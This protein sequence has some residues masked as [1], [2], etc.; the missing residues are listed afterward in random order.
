M[1]NLELYRKFEKELLHHR[2][3][4]GVGNPNEFSIIDNMEKAWYSVSSE[5]Q[6]ILDAE[7]PQCF[8]S[9][10]YKEYVDTVKEL[11]VFQNE[12][13]VKSEDEHKLLDKMNKAWHNMTD[14][15]KE[16]LQK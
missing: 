12:L 3:E 7:P 15:E 1:T 9:K 8:P 2:L 11:A 14:N 10:A 4:H 13:E 5:E 16:Y 6:Q